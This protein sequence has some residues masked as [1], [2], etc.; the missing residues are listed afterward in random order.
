MSAQNGDMPPVALSD[1]NFTL[2]DLFG[3]GLPDVL[4]TSA[5]GY[6]YWKNTGNGTFS[7]RRELK[8]MP[9]N[10]R[11]EQPGVGF[12]D[13]AGDGQ[14]DLLVHQG[15]NWGFFEAN[16]KGGWKNFKSYRNQPSFQLSDPNVRMLDMTGDGKS[17][18]LRTDERS[19]VW[20]PADGEKGFSAPK[21]IRRKN[22]LTQF[23]NVNFSD[24]RVKLADM[25]GDSLNDIVLVHS[26]R[27]DYWANMGN[28]H[29]SQRITME[30]P[31]RFG[32]DFD[33]SRLYLVDIDGSGTADLLYIES[34]KLRF[35]FNQSGNCFGKEQLINGTPSFTNQDAV[36]VTDLLGCGCNGVLWTTNYRGA[37][38][39]HYMFL[40]FSGGL[41]P[42]L[43]FEMDNNMGSTTKAQYK[44]STSFYLKDEKNNHKRNWVTTLP[45]PVQVLEKVEKIDHISRTKLVTNYRYHHGYY[46][47][48][49]REFR[50]FAYVEQQDTER[51]DTF[52]QEGLHHGEEIRNS[53][54]E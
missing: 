22:D 53:S 40:D 2:V 48:K 8:N 44:P 5:F 7:G 25:T 6:Y 41:K 39:P 20:F 49:E 10:V 4:Q 54:K 31:P 34:G 14:A 52:G 17:D 13:L 50:G 12:G 23:P 21:H 32:A 46:D 47:G 35:W 30:M 11:L 51:F 19:F 3:R 26:G 27:I 9:T 16:G 33:P 1:P 43:L 24:P 29:F 36:Q 37:N 38:R 45:F 42:N 18:V 15:I 28:G